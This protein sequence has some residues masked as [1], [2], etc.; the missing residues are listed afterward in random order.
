MVEHLAIIMDGNG[1]W[2]KKRGLPR[3]KG[4]EA[5]AETVRR[6]LGYCRKYGVK[7]LTL[8]AFSTENWSRPAAEVSGLMLLLRKFLRDNVRELHANDIRLRVIGRRGD[9]PKE[10]RK[11]VEAAE[12]E[13]AGHGS[14][15][16]LVALSYGGRAEL[17]DAARALARDVAA[18][19][20]DPESIDESAV[21]SR[22]YAP[23]VPDPDLIV[24][25]SGELRLSN[26]LLWEAAYS[27]LYVTP[28][29]WPDFGEEDFK[30]ALDAFAARDR[31][32]GGLSAAPAPAT[33]ENGGKK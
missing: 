26:F 17:A 31:R 9:L 28:V 4:H 29:L 32:Y 12:A 3:L 1:R 21:A 5:G 15:Q 14:G 7:Y 18:G 16:L 6:V 25:T 2:A 30:A 24:R 19:K 10:V 20:V 33:P 27:E 23:D 22:L 11:A 13:T 8:Y